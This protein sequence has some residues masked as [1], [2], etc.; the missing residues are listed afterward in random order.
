MVRRTDRPAMT[1]AVD[2]GHKETNKQ[3]M[4][5]PKPLYVYGSGHTNK[6]DAIFPPPRH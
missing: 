6:G 4:A 1:I 2:L 3:Q 5:T